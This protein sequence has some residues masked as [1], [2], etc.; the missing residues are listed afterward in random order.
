[1]IPNCSQEPSQRE[2]LSILY[3]QARVSNSCQDCPRYLITRLNAITNYRRRY[4]LPELLDYC[5]P[6]CGA[7]GAEHNEGVEFCPECGHEIG[8]EVGVATDQNKKVSDTVGGVSDKPSNTLDSFDAEDH[9][10]LTE[11]EEILKKRRPSPWSSKNRLTV[12]AFLVLISIPS[13]V[14]GDLDTF[15]IVGVF[16]PVL[17]FGY[18]VSK[19]RRQM[20]VFT[21]KRAFSVTF[22]SPLSGN[23]ANQSDSMVTD[24]WLE[25][26]G[27]L[28]TGS[29]FIESLISKFTGSSAGHIKFDLSGSLFSSGEYYFSMYEHEEPAKITKK[30]KEGDK[31]ALQASIGEEEGLPEAEQ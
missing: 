18:A 23:I 31:D 13:A 10:N 1:M 9:I 4:I 15:L 7:C 17:L 16:I 20:Y 25:D 21:N 5:M 24:F 19:N 29:S 27:A 30:I 6:Y 11:G 3:P 14:S 8:S 22:P 28:S 26:I 2:S 12:G